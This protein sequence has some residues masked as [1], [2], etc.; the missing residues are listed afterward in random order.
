MA[1]DIPPAPEAPKPKQHWLKKLLL[2]LFVV[3]LIGGAGAGGW[4][5]QKRKTDDQKNKVTQLQKQ[6]D[7][8]KK[9]N[10]ELMA[11]HEHAATDATADWTEYKNTAGKFTLKYEP[12]WNIKVCPDNP[13]TVFIA[14]TVAAQAVCQS[15]KGAPISVSSLDGDQRQIDK[16]GYPAGASGVTKSS[17]TVNG[18]AGRRAAFTHDGDE[19]IPAGTK[20]V[21]YEFF[22]NG[23]TYHAVY[24]QKPTDTDMLS[25]FE[26]LVT[27]TLKFSAS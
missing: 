6:V 16:A 4:Y 8:L 11:M 1:Q 7:D 3:L 10:E 19:F 9:S 20:Q 2:L 5:Y 27:K 15:E 18:V 22:T 26:L 17:I 21:E 24:I 23:R 13:T 25:D 12:S 14:P